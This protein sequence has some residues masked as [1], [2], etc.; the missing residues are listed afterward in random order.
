MNFLAI[1]T[2]L[3]TM[4]GAFFYGNGII[5]LKS[6]PSFIGAKT[7]EIKPLVT[8]NDISKTDKYE[9]AN[10]NIAVEKLRFVLGTPNGMT[11]WEEKALAKKT[12]SYI[13]SEFEGK[14][15]VKGVSENGASSMIKKCDIPRTVANFVSWN[16]FVEKFPE[17][18]KEERL[19]TKEEFDFAGQVYL[20]FYSK[21]FLKTKAIQYVWTETLPVETISDNPYTNNVK[22]I[23]LESGKS[24]TWK[25]EHRNFVKDYE[26]LFEEKMDTH[27]QAVAF[28]TD[29]DST[30]STAIAYYG[31]F[32]FETEELKQIYNKKDIADITDDSNKNNKIDTN[33]ENGFSEWFINTFF[34]KGEE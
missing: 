11:D 6:S 16:W 13:L 15:C 32:T 34:R 20:V 23:V 21:F 17:R 24:E 14:P 27:I 29:S 26:M 18:K 8:S 31:D 12:S 25:H 10:E 19:N 1:L 7:P 2:I 9:L 3:I 22:I 5:T 33:N 28:M 30:G 4:L